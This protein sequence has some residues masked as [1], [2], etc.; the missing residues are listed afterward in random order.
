MLLDFSVEN[1]IIWTQGNHQVWKSAKQPWKKSSENTKAIFS[2]K[3]CLLEST[4][5]RDIQRLRGRKRNEGHRMAGKQG[6]NRSA[7][8]AWWLVYNNKYITKGN[9]SVWE[10]NIQLISILWG[11]SLTLGD[12]KEDQRKRLKEAVFSFKHSLNV[13]E[14]K[15]KNSWKTPRVR[16]GRDALAEG[17]AVLSVFVCFIFKH[18]E[19][20]LEQHFLEQ[21]GS[22]GGERGCRERGKCGWKNM[23][24]P[25]MKVKI[26]VW[27]WIL[28]EYYTGMGEKGKGGKQRKKIYYLSRTKILMRKKTV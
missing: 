24:S 9:L 8:S 14:R 4:E 23:I 21:K 16:S 1:L 20:L 6:E 25:G 22:R 12:K 26:T 5:S 17:T 10:D 27:N 7:S 19:P 15:S 18:P 28:L 3:L 2:W 11:H 13:M